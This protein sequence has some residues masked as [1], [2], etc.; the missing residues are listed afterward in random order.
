MKKNKKA[1][2]VIV[3]LLMIWFLLVVVVW[4]F[5]LVLKELN[6]NRWMWNYI[7]AFFWAEAWQELALLQIKDKWYG[8]PDKIDLSVNNRSI[9]LSENPVNLSLF[10]WNSDVLVSYDIPVKTNSYTWVLSSLWYDIIPLYY[11]TWNIVITEEWITDLNFGIISWIESDLVWNIIWNESWFSWIWTFNGDTI[12]DI[13]TNG[14]SWFELNTKEIKDFL[15]TSST[16]FLI[17]LNSGDSD[18]TYNLKTADQDE[19]FSK[20][21]LK[22]FSSSKV[23]N[24]KQNLSTDFDNSEY[25]K[26]LKYSIYSN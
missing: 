14:V 15:T 8:Y 23:W 22:I 7:K 21:K 11:L 18:L 16:N 26:I 1:Y 9:I 3:A 10:K 6:D 5:N 24:Y 12:V 4:V 17:L 13:K 19:Y 2:S 25:F 20:P